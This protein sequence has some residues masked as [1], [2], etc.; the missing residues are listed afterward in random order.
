MYVSFR[1]QNMY[2]YDLETL[3]A[4]NLLLKKKNDDAR[5]KQLFRGFSSNL[6]RIVN[7]KQLHLF[8]YK[9]GQLY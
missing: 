1:S 7:E 3:K 5:K 2:L 8:Y 6:K 9:R 4:T